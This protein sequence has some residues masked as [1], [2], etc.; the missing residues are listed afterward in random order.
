MGRTSRV[1]IN[2][3]SYFHG[4]FVSLEGSDCF[5]FIVLAVDFS[6]NFCEICYTCFECLDDFFIFF[7]WFTLHTPAAHL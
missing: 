5:F 7:L 1:L 2:I 3:N 4:S 6:W